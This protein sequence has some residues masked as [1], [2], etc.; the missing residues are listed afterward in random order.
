MYDEMRLTILQ[1][2]NIAQIT[3]LQSLFTNQIKCWFL[4]TGENGS[5]RGKAFFTAEGYYL[6]P[7]QLQEG[8]DQR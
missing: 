7:V 3:L 8:L 6:L 4:M 2:I 5:T 1:E